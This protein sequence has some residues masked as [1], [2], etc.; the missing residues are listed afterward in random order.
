MRRLSLRLRL[1]FAFALTMSLV[2]GAT[3]II[4]YRLTASDLNATI[5]RSLISRSEEVGVL[6]N[7]SG[8]SLAAALDR[9]SNEEDDFAQV[10]TAA[11]RVIASTP[12][13]DGMSLMRPAT[14]LRAAHKGVFAEH[15]PVAQL[16]GALRIHAEPVATANGRLIIAAGTTLGERDQ[17]LQTLA[18]LLL[19]AGAAALLLSSLAGYAV[20]SGALRPVEAIRRRAATI[21]EAD[22][23]QRLPVSPSGDEI[24]RL[25]MTLNEMLDRLSA[26]FA[27]ERLFVADASHELRTPLAILKAE[28]ELAL[29]QERSAHE[30]RSALVS[31]GDETDRL[32][33]LAE[34]L[35]VIA[36]LDQGRLPMRAERIPCRELL[37]T[38]AARH[39]ARAERDRH[40]IRVEC[41]EEPSISGDRAQ[42]EQ[43]LGNLLDNA[44]RH[45][46]SEVTLIAIARRSVV[47]LHVLDDGPGFEP[48]LLDRAFER[49]VR[50]EGERS[51]EGA[52]LGLA[53]ATA[54]A[55]AHGGHARAANQPGGGAD[56]WLELPGIGAGKPAPA[57]LRAV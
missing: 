29:R 19:I 27:R 10:L 25:G 48:A 6:I 35:L 56:V 4:V 7:H 32:A 43:A 39:R 41:S 37:E 47:E 9:V 5:D 49:F 40:T 51:R 23:D 44:L 18:R 1:T 31:I 16:D 46:A 57:S 20:A 55:R 45:G 36:R 33:S 50:G 15:A 42:L 2:L 8:A 34:D 14:R 13:V 11:G 52:G 26:A 54:V 24:S 53:I 12:Q 3:G 17:S 38:V 30:L 21:S 22:S 28:V